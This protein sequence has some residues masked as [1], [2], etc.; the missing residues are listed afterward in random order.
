MAPS[1]ALRP[2]FI[3]WP[4]DGQTSMT[5]R[6]V[7]LPLVKRQ[8]CP[9]STCVNPWGPETAP[10]AA[11]PYRLATETEMLMLA[12]VAGPDS[13]A[14]HDASAKEIAAARPAPANRARPL[15]GETTVRGPTRSPKMRSNAIPCALCAGSQ[16]VPCDYIQYGAG[17][18]AHLVLPLAG[19]LLR[20]RSPV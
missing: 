3:D 20:S 6:D 2:L 12:E 8:N 7:P 10:V 18:A 17:R 13:G 15:A 5:G 4:G 1:D 11:K 14:A 16:K 19:P 9:G